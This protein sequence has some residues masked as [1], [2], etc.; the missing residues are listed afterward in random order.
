MQLI[1]FNG[2]VSIIFFLTNYKYVLITS[3]RLSLNVN[4][5]HGAGN[6]TILN[7]FS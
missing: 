1:N 7:C 6:E 2:F 3:G 5:I 4:H